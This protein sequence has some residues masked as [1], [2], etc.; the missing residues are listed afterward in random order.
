MMLADAKNWLSGGVYQ[1]KLHPKTGATALHVAAAKGYIKVL[2]YV[3]EYYFKD[4][5]DLHCI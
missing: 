5:S 3:N 2:E 4:L 1:D